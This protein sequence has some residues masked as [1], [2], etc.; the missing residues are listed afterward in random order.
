MAK[1]KSTKLKSKKVEEKIEKITLRRCESQS[2]WVVRDSIEI[3][4]E[5]YP[6]LEGKSMEEI[7]EYIKENAHEMKSPECCEWAD[8]LGDALDQQDIIR[9]KDMGSELVTY[10]E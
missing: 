1:T 7:E 2:L 4:V 6:E 9:E 3:T 5:E 10:F 8:S